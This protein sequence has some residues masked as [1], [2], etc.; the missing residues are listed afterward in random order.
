M[1]HPVQRSIGLTSNSSA[2]QWHEPVWV[3]TI[4]SV[5]PFAPDPMI[6]ASCDKW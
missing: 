1:A 5:T 6:C 2:P 4:F 3:T